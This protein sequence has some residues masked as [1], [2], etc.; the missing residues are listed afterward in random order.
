MRPGST[1]R[2][3][4]WAIVGILLTLG[5]AAYL[6]LLEQFGVS[7]EPIERGFSTVGKAKQ[8]VQLYIEAVA[9]NVP[10]NSMQ[11]RV[12][13][14]PSAALRGSLMTAPDR[15]LSLLI[16]HGETIQELRFP[17]NVPAAPAT[18][19]VTLSKGQVADYPLDVYQADLGLQC[20]PTA[21]TTTADVKPLPAEITVWEALLGYQMETTQRPADNPGEVH[22]A[23]EIHRS[24]AFA[25]FALLAYGAM[26]V[27]GCCALA[28]G[29]LV[30]LGVRRVE[31]TLIGALGAIVF[32]LPALRNA[33]PGAPPLGVRADTL[34]FLW[35]EIAAAIALGLLV[36]AWSRN[37]PAP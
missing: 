7:D 10:D 11:L 24:G 8:F 29:V 19:E 33:L 28:V 35:T 21:S 36:Y 4:R 6:I 18:F 15:D 5:V 26:A 1:K 17:A 37:G 31:G 30:F 23:L 16:T 27:L 12:S 9:V 13:L 14:T 2:A 25:L 32:A 20:L 3:F 34:V 22:L